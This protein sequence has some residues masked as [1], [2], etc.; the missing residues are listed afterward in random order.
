M[1]GLCG[2][3]QELIDNGDV[4]D[5]SNDHGSAIM[6]VHLCGPPSLPNKVICNNKG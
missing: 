1:C 2:S 3:R 6:T 5:L 4:G